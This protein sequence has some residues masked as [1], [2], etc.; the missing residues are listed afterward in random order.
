MMKK[1][2][3]VLTAIAFAAT[4]SIQAGDKAATKTKGAKA[5]AKENCAACPMA[6]ASAEKA[7]GTCTAEQASTKAKGTCATEQAS[8]KAK[9]GCCGAEASKQVARKSADLTKGAVRLVS[10]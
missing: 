8:T 9:S 3:L 4:L 1:L 5:E 10:K 6:K 2:L 7:K